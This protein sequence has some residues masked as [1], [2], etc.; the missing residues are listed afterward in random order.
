[1]L[2]RSE[3]MA[4]FGFLGRVRQPFASG[5]TALCAAWKVR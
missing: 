4:T 2:L 5:D 3:K 1:M